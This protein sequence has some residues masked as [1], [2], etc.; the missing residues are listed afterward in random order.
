MT[1][2]RPVA[3]F[4]AHLEKIPGFLV[5]LAA[6]H[7]PTARNFH[8]SE[9]NSASSEGGPGLPALPIA[10]KGPRNFSGGKISVRAAICGSPL[11]WL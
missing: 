7:R 3:A 6:A 5:R 4:T 11:P 9:K 10:T 2:S 8:L 1:R